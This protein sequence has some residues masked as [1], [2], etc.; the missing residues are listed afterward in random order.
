[1][2]TLMGVVLAILGIVLIFFIAPGTVDMSLM[3]VGWLAFIA[4]GILLTWGL[5]E[6]QKKQIAEADVL[7]VTTEAVPGKKI[8]KTLG[9][10]QARNNPFLGAALAEINARKN[11]V[12]EARKLGANA[13]VGVRTERQQHK[14][15]ITYYMYGTAV[16]LEDSE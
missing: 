7:V 5:Y 8:V 13:V 11:L 14:E 12:Q 2:K 10:V 16:V 4:G 3:I 15:Q 9:T 1:M 6:R